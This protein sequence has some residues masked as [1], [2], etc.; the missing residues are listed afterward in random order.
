MSLSIDIHV[1]Q[2]VPPSNINRDD[3]GSPKTAVYGG[4]RR[5]R[6]SS[7]AWKRATRRDFERYL[8][9]SEFGVRTKRAVELLSERIAKIQP[10]L[11][12]DSS[13][14]KATAVLKA[15]GLN[16][17]A[18]RKAEEGD[19]ELTEYLVFFSNQQLDKLAELAVASGDS[20]PSGVA[21]KKVLKEGNSFDLALFGRM[22]AN[23]ADLNV[24]AACQVA[25]ALST[26]AVT[27]EFDYFTAVDD[28][29]P[30]DETG[31]GMIGTVE[32]NSATLYR[33]ATV[34]VGALQENLGHAEA[35]SRAVEAFV[36]SFVQSMP[37]GKQ[38]TFANGT[39]PEA[40]VVM[41]QEGRA[42]NLVGAFEDAV[43]SKDGGFVRASCG[44][45][46]TY[47][48]D[49]AGE[50]AAKP[51]A[52]WVTRI[53]DQTASLDAL[54]KRVTFDDLVTGLGELVRASLTEPQ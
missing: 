46:A 5:A 4:V 23:D 50:Y 54:G 33:Y 13:V 52:A 29:N 34:S 21:A 45:L 22:V 12:G 37:T 48:Q 30:D 3:A 9:T 43:G 28:K 7:Q 10:E 1:I 35:T 24:D 42:V 40:V 20:A 15:A 25:H 53:G 32:F 26:H 6:V 31:A 16:T 2:S 49:V 51:V 27:N 8:D 39:L 38:N 36:R 41:A 47:A 18:K 17:K 14:A 44:K 19:L 11:E